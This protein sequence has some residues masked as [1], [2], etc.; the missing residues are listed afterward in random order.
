MNIDAIIH[1]F[2]ISM[3]CV[4]YRS[5]AYFDICIYTYDSELICL[6][7]TYKDEQESI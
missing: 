4:E 7:Q 1:F 6:I 5:Q 3:L 2:L